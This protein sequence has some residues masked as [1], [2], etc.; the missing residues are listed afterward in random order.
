MTFGNRGNA[1][2]EPF[3]VVLLIVVLAIVS[4]VLYNILSDFNT[5]IQADDDYANTTKTVVSDATARHPQVW[6]NAIL[7]AFV[8]AWAGSI[9]LAFLIDSHPIFFI[10]SFLG[11]IFMIFVAAYLA[12]TYTELVGEDATLSSFSAD[13]PKTNFLISNL[14][15]V[16]I[17]VFG[18][19]AMALFAKLRGT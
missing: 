13:Y 10:F 19:V 14:V 15:L 11:V 2:V 12:N 1:L 7:F 3:T 8:L 18:S 16:I 5:E 6:D 4:V 17:V 9:A